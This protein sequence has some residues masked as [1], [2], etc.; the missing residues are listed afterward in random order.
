MTKQASGLY[1]YNKGKPVKDK[2][3]AKIISK[4]TVSIFEIKIII[5]SI[6]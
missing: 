4:R 5:F 3:V 1:L 2:N 6:I